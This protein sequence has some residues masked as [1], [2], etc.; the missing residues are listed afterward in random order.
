MKRRS[1]IQSVPVVVGGV[2]VNA[3]GASPMLSAM[4]SALYETD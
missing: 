2:T 4:T 3:Y 1:F